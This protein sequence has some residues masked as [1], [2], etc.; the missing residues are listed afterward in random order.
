MSRNID[1]E[2][3]RELNAAPV[4][5]SS[6][7]LVFLSRQAKMQSNNSYLNF[8]GNKYLG[9]S[10]TAILPHLPW[11]EDPAAI[12]LLLYSSKLIYH[13]ANPPHTQYI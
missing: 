11:T 10:S 12:W 13:S 6:D 9:C 8:M 1:L 2:R 4:T 3:V 7:S 5:I